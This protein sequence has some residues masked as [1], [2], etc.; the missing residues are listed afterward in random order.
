MIP[1]IR[2]YWRNPWNPCRWSRITAGTTPRP[3]R[4]CW[5]RRSGGWSS[6]SFGWV[7]WPLLFP[8]LPGLRDRG[9]GLA[10][11]LGWLIIGWVHWMGV[12]LGLWENRAPRLP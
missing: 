2:C 3:R 9:Y 12:S 10:R 5:L 6:A 4:R 1:P 8:L 7:V 11:A